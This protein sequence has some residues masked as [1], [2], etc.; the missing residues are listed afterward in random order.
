MLICEIVLFLL[1]IN[2]LF[3][4][5]YVILNKGLYLVEME[6]IFLDLFSNFLVDKS[7]SLFVR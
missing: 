7:V 6:V 2:V 3:V 4:L 1:V 5:I